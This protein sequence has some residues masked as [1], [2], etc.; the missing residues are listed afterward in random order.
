MDD[1]LVH[2]GVKG[3]KWG[4]RRTPAQLGHDIKKKLKRGKGDD[5]DSSSEKS[6]GSA[7]G[8]SGSKNSRKT[9]KRIQD[10]SDSELQSYY[11]RLNLERNTI[12]AQMQLAQLSP[13]KASL[14]RRMVS[15]VADQVIK[16][17]VLNAGRNYLQN[18]LNKKQTSDDPLKPLRD[19]VEELRLRS[20]KVTFEDNIR[21]RTGG[22][23]SSG[24]TSGTDRTSSTSSSTT[25]NRAYEQTVSTGRNFITNDRMLMDT[26][27]AGLLP[28]GDDDYRRR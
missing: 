21:K 28:P 24:G 2:Y 16:P 26:S 6:S 10:M 23:S 3:M 12:Q 18:A 11:N 22:S 20:Q 1:V 15:T 4:I 5:D 14:G 27:I 7:K 8:S 25:S 13:K 9:K 17:A 19:E